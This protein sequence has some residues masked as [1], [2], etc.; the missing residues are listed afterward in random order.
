VS[1]LGKLV[2]ELRRSLA[3]EARLAKA[4]R[5]VQFTMGDD[6]DQCGACYQIMKH[7]VGC[8]VQVALSQAEESK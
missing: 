3:S 2:T 6:V 7:A 5:R 8:E 1:A 4:L